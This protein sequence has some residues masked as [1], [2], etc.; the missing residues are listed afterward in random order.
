[1]CLITGKPWDWESRCSDRTCISWTHHS[2]YV[3]NTLD[4]GTR[5][6]HNSIWDKSLLTDWTKTGHCIILSSGCPYTQLCPVVFFTEPSYCIIFLNKH[7]IIMTIKSSHYKSLKV[8][9]YEVAF[10]NCAS[11]PSSGS[12]LKHLFPGAGEKLSVRVWCA[13]SF[14]C[15]DKNSFIKNLQ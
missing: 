8:Y 11:P 15:I 1:M 9:R 14:K 3:V 6:S 4:K 13:V 5:F 7:Y 12:P 2:R 10:W